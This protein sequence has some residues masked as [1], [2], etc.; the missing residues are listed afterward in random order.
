[1]ERGAHV[2]ILSGGYGAVLATEPIGRYDAR[3][4]RSCW[5][6]RV[7]ERVLANYAERQSLRFVRAF[8]SRTTDYRKIL[9]GILWRDTG[10]REAIPITPEVSGGAMRKSPATQGEALAALISVALTGGWKSS[11]G[12]GVEALVMP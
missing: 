3:L 9:E 10:I 5:P 6:D 7:I 4:E 12:L 2:I 8:A 11:S 1:M